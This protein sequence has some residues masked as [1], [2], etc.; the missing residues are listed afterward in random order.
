MSRPGTYKI[1]IVSFLLALSFSFCSK[2]DDTVNT[3][4]PLNLT[5]EVLSI[6][7]ETGEVQIQASAQNTT[8]YQL[9][10]GSSDTPVED[11]TTG[12]FEYTFAGQGYFEFNVRAYGASGKY[13]KVVKEITIAPEP[14]PIP[15]SRG[16][17]SPMEYTGYDL[18]W[19]DEFNGTQINSSNWGYDIGTGDWGW[20]NNELQYYRIENSWVADSVLTIEARNEAFSGQLYTSSRLKTQGKVSFQYGR[21]DVRAVLPKGQGMWPAIWMLGNNITQIGWPDCGEIDIM[22]MIGGSENTVHGTAHWEFNGSQASEGGSESTPSNDYDFTESYHVFSIVWD[23]NTI[24]WYVDNNQYFGLDITS[25]DMSEFHQPHFFIL[26]V[27]VGGNWPG[28]PNSTTIFP[29][30]MKVDY[31][32]VFQQE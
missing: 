31:I 15:L 23:E 26:N 5:V 24:Q 32:R 13:I 6:D 4:D 17:L 9:Y 21:I 7:N 1:S 8:L 27:A 19:Q 12:Y 30:Q 2:S 10:I 3:D 22:E 14:E 25:A 18:V 28:N 16:F 20:G 29:Q 11:N